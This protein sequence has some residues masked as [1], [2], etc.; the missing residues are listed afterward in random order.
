M[1]LM[2]MEVETRSSGM[3][4]RR[5]SMSSRVEMATPTFPTSPA[6]AGWSES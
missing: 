4:S 2:V 1:A 6:E 3:P 5:I